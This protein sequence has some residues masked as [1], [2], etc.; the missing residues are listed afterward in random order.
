M[1]SEGADIAAGVYDSYG[2]HP[3]IAHRYIDGTEFAAILFF[4]CFN[5]GRV[6]IA[7]MYEG[8]W[9]SRYI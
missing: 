8:K 5:D 1:E 6:Y 7:K 3:F 9:A 4:D 2:L